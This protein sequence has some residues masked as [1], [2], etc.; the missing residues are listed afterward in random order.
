MTYYLIEVSEKK[1]AYTISAAVM[2][3]NIVY[4]NPFTGV[5]DVRYINN[6]IENH[7][8]NKKR[9]TVNPKSVI[10]ILHLMGFELKYDS[11]TQ[12]V[13][14]KLPDHKEKNIDIQFVYNKYFLD[15]S[16]FLALSTLFPAENLSPLKYQYAY[17]ISNYGTDLITPHTPNVLDN[18]VLPNIVIPVPDT[19]I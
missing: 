7:S 12:F 19:K 6:N 1:V 5:I 10:F 11:E 17:Y 13:Q 8:Y 4:Y 18:L 15:D 14:V 16:A 2:K 9:N 3:G